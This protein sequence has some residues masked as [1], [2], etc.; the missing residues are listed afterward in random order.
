MTGA[1][2]EQRRRGC[3]VEPDTSADGRRIVQRKVKGS[4]GD[5]PLLKGSVSSVGKGWIR[6]LVPTEIHDIGVGEWRCVC[7]RTM[8][9]P[10]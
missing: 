4:G 9:G 1:E 2:C 10:S 5:G 8:M 3:R 6:V 7:R